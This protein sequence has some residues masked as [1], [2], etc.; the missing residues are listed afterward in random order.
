VDQKRN[1]FFPGRDVA[2]HPRSVFPL[3][4]VV[5]GSQLRLAGEIARIFQIVVIVLVLVIVVGVIG[6][7]PRLGRRTRSRGTA[8]AFL[9]RTAIASIARTSIA[10]TP[11]TPA[12]AAASAAAAA[13]RTFGFLRPSFG[14]G[15]VGFFEGSFVERGLV[16]KFFPLVERL[17]RLFVVCLRLFARSL[18]AHMALP[19]HRSC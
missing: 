18:V 16:G 1:G 2:V 8:P 11:L 17:A 10:R 7:R 19:I 12:A 14:R 13:R 4:A 9:T 15:F 5:F 6:H 3:F